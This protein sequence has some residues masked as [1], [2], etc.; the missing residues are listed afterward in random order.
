MRNILVTT[1]VH[2]LKGIENLLSTKGTVYY[3]QYG[4]KYDVRW[5]LTNYPIDTIL[6]NPNRQGYILDEYVLGDTKV[7]TINTCSTGLNHIDTKYCETAGIEILSLTHDR[8]L[9]EQLPSTSELAFSL[10]TVLLRNVYPA[11][12][13][14]ED[15]NWDYIPFVGRQIRGLNVGVVGFG[16]LGKM[17]ADYCT[18]FGCNVYVFD[19]YKT[20]T[21]YNQTTLEDIFT[22]CDVVSLH[23][24]VSDDTRYMINSDLLSL[25]E[26]LIVLKINSSFVSF[27]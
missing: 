26:L 3:C 24:H 14:V 25:N 5:W 20:S 10:M 21:G 12:C 1:P 27:G 17:F 13:S 9:L 19:P 23:V 11:I 2:H 15:G 6:C 22:N 4:T 16:R 8:P 18:A 7:K